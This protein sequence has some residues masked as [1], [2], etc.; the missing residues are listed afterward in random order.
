MAMQGVSLPHGAL[1]N[2]SS[3]SFLS[4]PRLHALPPL[5]STMS[6]FLPSLKALSKL[7]LTYT[8]FVLLSTGNT[9][10]GG[11]P[12][13]C[14][15]PQTSCQNTSAVAN[16]CCFNAPGGQLLQV[17][18]AAELIRPTPAHIMHADSVL[19]R[20]PLDRPSQLLDHPRPM[21][22]SSTHSPAV[23]C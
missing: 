9:V 16:T 23:A 18:Q 1:K 17:R 22:R 8:H 13:T 4:L 20:R 19:G 21:V 2:L 6:S 10:S 3:L 11:A 7:A 5:S 14:S 15:N 12:D